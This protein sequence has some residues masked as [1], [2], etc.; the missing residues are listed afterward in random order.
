MKKASRL[1]QVRPNGQLIMKP[2]H[3]LLRAEVD[4]VPAGYSNPEE[5]AWKAILSDCLS[6]TDSRATPKGLTV[7]FRLKASQRREGTDIDNLCEPIFSVLV[8]QKGWFRA[9]RSNIRWFRVQKWLSQSPGCSLLVLNCDALPLE[10]KRVVFQDLYTGPL[11]KSA[12]DTA[13]SYWLSAKIKRFDQLERCALGFEFAD[14]RLNIGDI[15]T[16]RVKSLV[17]SLY[18]ILGGLPGDPHDW[19]VN[20]LQVEKGVVDL[21]EQSLRLTVWQAQELPY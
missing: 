3:I 19:R 9:R 5:R 6:A 7:D 20:F 21:P 14:H 13:F 18:P 2:E 8:N 16:G 17:D 11:P 10:E 12:R 1:Y 15:A 4:G